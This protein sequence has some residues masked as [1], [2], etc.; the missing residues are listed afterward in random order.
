MEPKLIEDPSAPRGA[1]RI[2][3]S[4][5]RHFSKLKRI[6]ESSLLAPDPQ[7]SESAKQKHALFKEWLDKSG[8][9]CSKLK[10]PVF[11]AERPEIVYPGVMATEDIGRNET[12]LRVPASIIISVRRALRSELGPAVFEKYPQVFSHSGNPNYWECIDLAAGIIT[13]SV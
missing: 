9:V 10:Y 1:A 13:R 2:Q 3:F 12:I 7:F 8:T 4:F 11:F 5:R 6:G